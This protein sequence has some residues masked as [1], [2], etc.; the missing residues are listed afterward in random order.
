[1]LY[2]VSWNTCAGLVCCLVVVLGMVLKVLVLPAVALVG[3][4]LKDVV[5]C[6]VFPVVSLAMVLKEV[7]GCASVLVVL[8]VL[9]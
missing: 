4:V 8:C 7:V 6:T 5:G 1:M 2:D 3:V 9:A